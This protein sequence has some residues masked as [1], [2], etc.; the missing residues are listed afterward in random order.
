MD[1]DDIYLAR[2]RYSCDDRSTATTA[3]WIVGHSSSSLSLRLTFLVIF[4]RISLTCLMQVIVMSIVGMVITRLIK[5][6]HQV[7]VFNVLLLFANF[8]NAFLGTSNCPQSALNLT[9]N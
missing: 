9:S 2:S 8:P 3:F 6:K 4:S 5:P 1:L 7:P